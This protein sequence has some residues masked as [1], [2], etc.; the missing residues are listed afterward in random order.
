[1]QKDIHLPFTRLRIGRFLFLLISITLMFTLRPFL[2]G[3]IGIGILVDI[4]ATLILLSGV[5]AA[6]SNKHVFR[7]ALLIAFPALIAHWSNYFVKISSLFLASKIFGGFFYAFL[8]V[9]ILN[10]LFKEKQ[11]TTDVIAGAICA[12]FLIG[13]M[14]SSIFAI[15]EFAQPG[16]FDI[17]QSLRAESSSFA[18]Y[19]YVTLTTLG[20]GDITPITTQA[21][22]FSL[23]EAMT[24]QIYLATLV[25][26]L[27]SINILQSMEKESP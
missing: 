15:L 23:L 1:M 27:V 17:P 22:S 26:R 10:Y 21:A 16:S 12:Y 25:A 14:W 20:Y 18:Y 11:I 9:V 8:V 24:G 4:F 13:L 5:Y 6:S 7:I 2:E 3:F 19:S